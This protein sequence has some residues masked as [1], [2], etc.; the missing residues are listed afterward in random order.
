VLSSPEKRYQKISFKQMDENNLDQTIQNGW[1]G[2]VEH[3]F[4][5]AWVPNPISSYHYYTSAN[6][7]NDIYTIGLLSR[8]VPVGA[9]QQYAT[10]AQL[11][12]GPDIADKLAKI[13]P[14]MDLTVDYGM[15]WFIGIVIFGLMKKLYAVTGNWGWA[16]VLTTLIIKLL[17]YK[18]NSISFRSMAA[19][20]N[21]QPKLQ[22]IRERCGEDKQKLAQATM[23]LYKR[24]KVNPLGGCLPMLVQIPVFLALYWVLAGSVELRQAPFILWIHDLSAKDPYYVL[25]LLMGLTIFIQQ[26]LS[27]KA[28]DPMQQKVMMMMPVIFT[29]LF[30]SFPA[31]LVLYW[32]VNNTLSILQQWYIMNHVVPKAQAKKAQ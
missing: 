31:G 7:E 5:S 28:P 13:A 27:P 29:A 4:I 20:R 10:G 9:H 30:L 19:M 12:A 32:V 22:Q 3:Y 25:P 16:I 11:Y 8:V 23:E 17:F 21:L 18:L 6:A 15:L 26:W 24:E 14:G 1:L 2:M